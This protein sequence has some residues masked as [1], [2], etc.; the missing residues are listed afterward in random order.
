MN[1]SKAVVFDLGK[2]LVDFDYSIAARKF[3]AQAN[4]TPNEIRE[5]IDHSPLLFE[6][7]HGRLSRREFYNKVCEATGFCGKFEDFCPYFSDIFQPI[8]EMVQVHKNLKQRGIPTYIFSNTNELAIEH[9]SAV[10]PFFNTFTDYILSFKVGVMKPHPPIYEVVE[11]ITRRRGAE[12]VYIDDRPEN[13][14]TGLQRGWHGII[15][16]SPDET[17]SR[18]MDLGLPVN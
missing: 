4:K 7:E 12:L 8:D 10:Y 1:A 14:A 11:R 9:I 18:L 13:V 2:V 15:H 3:A 6:F 17:I 5:L 16:Q